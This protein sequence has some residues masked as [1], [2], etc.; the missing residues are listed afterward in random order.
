M[1][2]EE[3][4]DVLWPKFANVRTGIGRTAVVAKYLFPACKKKEKEK[5]KRG[6]SAILQGSLSKFLDFFHMGTFIDSTHSKL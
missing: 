2:A 4:V 3:R 6:L 1:S 5:R